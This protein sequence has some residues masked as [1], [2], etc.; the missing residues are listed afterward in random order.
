MSKKRGSI[1]W[2]S[3]TGVSGTQPTTEESGYSAARRALNTLK[4][5][6]QP[7]AC[8]KVD[9]ICF[10]FDRSFVRPDAKRAFRRFARLRDRYPDAPISLFGHADPV[11]ND[12]YNKKL[13]EDRAKAVY[14]V[15]TRKTAVW[16]ELY[17]ARYLQKKL[18]SL[19]HDPGP[20]DGVYGPNTEAAI[21]AYMKALCGDFRL[22]DADFLGNGECAYQGCSEF[23][24]IRMFSQKMDQELRSQDR[25]LE[26]DAANQ[27]NRRVLAFLFK[28]DTEIDPSRW[29][30]PS[31]AEGIGGC[32]ER[33]WTDAG[34]RR[35]YQAQAR[36]FNRDQQSS[37]REELELDGFIVLP[38]PEGEPE[39]E[40]DDAAHRYQDSTDTFAC[41]FYEQLARYS[42]C[43]K[44]VDA[45]MIE[46]FLPE[47]DEEP[48]PE[49]E[50]RFTAGELVRTGKTVDGWMREY[51]PKGAPFYEVEWREPKDPNAPPSSIAKEEGDQDED[52][53]DF[54]D[55]EYPASFYV[56]LDWA[57]P[58]RGA[59]GVFTGSRGE[60][61]AS[62]PPQEA[63]NEE[64]VEYI[65]MPD[66]VP[67][68]E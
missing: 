39:G 41:R 31:A 48:P 65:E 45:V 52:E 34:Q 26:R 22:H 11:G 47:T 16:K 57:E 18:A 58:G 17:E 55:A 33:F 12:V 10:D 23:N 7:V 68:T 67:R 50:Y 29:P 62:E 8:W 56:D 9:D 1:I 19:G 24:P 20:V 63:E 43:E 15:L 32:K 35:Q 40:Q 28:P 25:K 60:P 30:C 61:S 46:M 44:V 27:P 5:S 64:E 38:E 4:P 13:S 3:E 54:E 6:L 21:L 14:G 59:V 37:S 51:L 66:E 49:Y 2:E 36:E 53:D 42:P